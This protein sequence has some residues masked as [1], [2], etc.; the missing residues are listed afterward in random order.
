PNL[1]LADSSRIIKIDRGGKL[2]EQY[3][4][5]AGGPQFSGI[6]DMAISGDGTLAYVLTNNALLE[7]H[8]PLAK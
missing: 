3:M 7:V 1:Y 8:M 6:R 4:P 2:L 5:A